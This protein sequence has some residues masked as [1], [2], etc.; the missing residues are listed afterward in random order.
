MEA[1]AAGFVLGVIALIATPRPSHPPGVCTTCPEL[2]LWDKKRRAYVHRK[3]GR[4]YRT[5]PY[6]RRFV[7]A[8]AAMSDSLL[9]DLPPV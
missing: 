3:D 9:Y 1:I 4:V 2:V 6:G 7:A 5:R 8:H